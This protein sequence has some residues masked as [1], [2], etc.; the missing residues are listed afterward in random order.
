MSR[1]LWLEQG[2]LGSTGP[3]LQHDHMGFKIPPAHRVRFLAAHRLHFLAAG[4]V[5]PNNGGFFCGAG[6]GG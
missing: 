4:T 6:A 1:P 5:I 2:T 3:H